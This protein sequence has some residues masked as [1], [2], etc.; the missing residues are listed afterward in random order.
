M[1]DPLDRYEIVNLESLFAKDELR[2]AAVLLRGGVEV[3]E[4]WNKRDLA[5]YCVAKGWLASDVREALV[6]K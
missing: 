2:K 1:M 6:V 3:P 5:T 4:F